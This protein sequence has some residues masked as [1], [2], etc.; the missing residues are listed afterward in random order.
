[1]VLDLIAGERRA[2]WQLTI[3]GNKTLCFVLYAPRTLE[4]NCI[5]NPFCRCG[6]SLI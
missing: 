6:T 3:D 5:S 2:A 4:Q 1:M